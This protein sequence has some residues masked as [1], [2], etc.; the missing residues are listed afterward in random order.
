MP[1]HYQNGCRVCGTDFINCRHRYQPLPSAFKFCQEPDKMKLPFKFFGLIAPLLSLSVLLSAFVGGSSIAQATKRQ[2][3]AKAIFL[4]RCKTAGKRIS[5]RVDNVEGIYVMKLRPERPNYS[6]QF[7]MND[8]Y[9]KDLGG[10]WGYIGSFLRGE[11]Q[12]THIG[13]P[14]EGSPPRLGYRYVEAQD[15]SDGQRYRYVGSMKEVT[16]TSSVLMGGDGKTTFKTK[17]F[18]LDQ[19]PAVTPGPRYGVTYDDI[20]TREEREYWIAGS[21]LKVIDLQ[22]SEVIAERVGYMMDWAQGSKAGGRSP[23]LL[24]ADNACPEFASKRGARAQPYQALDFV[25]E[26]LKPV[27]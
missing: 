6:D 24:A 7:A 12:A 2:D 20:S 5:R 4:E 8:P 15:P 23:W 25:E 16:N 27:R 14:K 22:T 3:K 19:L 26:V 9:G 13:V 11:F 21:S 10:K 17:K 1:Q 18:V